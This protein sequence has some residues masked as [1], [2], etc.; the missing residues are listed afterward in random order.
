[1]RHVERCGTRLS[2]RPGSSPAEWSPPPPPGAPADR[3]PCA[4][5]V[6]L[7]WRNDT[8]SVREAVPRLHEGRGSFNMPAQAPTT[9]T[10]EREAQQTRLTVTN[11][12]LTYHIEQV[13]SKLAATAV[14]VDMPGKSSRASCLTTP[15]LPPG[16]SSSQGHRSTSDSSLSSFSHWQA[17][18]PRHQTIRHPLRGH[19]HRWRKDRWTTKQ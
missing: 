10:F 19:C 9:E 18:H 3:P 13:Y 17:Y 8:S 6:S 15:P 7:V 5:E 14:N 1:M 2:G 12:T 11:L 4:A 16:T